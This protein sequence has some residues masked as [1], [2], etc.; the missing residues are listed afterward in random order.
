MRL[1]RL[2]LTRYGR[3]TD[4]RLDFPAPSPG[5]PDLHVIFGPN[6]AGKSTLFSAWLDLLY[7]IPARSRYDF[8]HPG[9]T[10]QIGARLTHDGGV[11]EA[12][13][14]KRNGASLQDANGQPL[15]EAVMQAALAGLG[16]DGYTAMFSLDDDTLEQGGESILASRG[17]LGEMLFSASAGLSGLGP[18]LDGVRK[19]LDAFHKPRARATA[20]K[21]ARD[22]LQDLD[23]QRRDLDISASAA[24]KL[25]RDLAAAEKAWLAAR[26]TEAVADAALK[27]VTE[28]LARLPQ[29]DRL[30]RLRNEL[31]PLATLPAATPE[32][33]R[34]LA[35][36][37]QSLRGIAGQMQTR[38]EALADLVQR[39]ASLSRDPAILPLAEHIAKAAGLY[40]LH[41]AALADL[42]KRRDSLASIEADLSRQMQALGL[43]G[44]PADHSIP[45]TT[46]SR[47]R[48]LV[49]QRDVLMQAFATARDEAA[50]GAARLKSLR[51]AI[52][53]LPPVEDLQSLSHLV[54]RLRQSD[55]E[56][57]VRRA[58]QE[59]AE[60]EG[61]LK[62][63]LIPLAPWQGTAH[64]L[65][66]LGVPAPWQI[67][68]WEDTEKTT[69]R[70]LRDAQ[71][72][73][74]R[75]QAALNEISVPIP[76]ASGMGNILAQAARLRA[77][78][79]AA[80]ATHLARMTPQTAEVFEEALRMDDQMAHHLA[81]AKLAAKW[82]EDTAQT[83]ARLTGEVEAAQADLGARQTERQAFEQALAD[84]A[85]T[86]GL[87]GSDAG[88][89][90][91]RLKAWLALRDSALI[92]KARRD[93][94]HAALDQAGASLK[95]AAETLA[96]ALALPAPTGFSVLWAEALT[97]LD[98]A[99]QR[100]DNAHRLAEAQSDLAERISAQDR[101][102]RAVEDWQGEWQ[103]ACTGTRLTAIVPTDMGLA[104]LLD[105]LDDLNRHED[106]RAELADRIA[107]M[108]ANSA[109][110]HAA[111]GAVFAA[112]SLPAETQW[113]GIADRLAAAQ[114]AAQDDQ[115]ITQDLI[116]LN[117]LQAAEADAARALEG[118]RSALAQRLG[119]VG[120]GNLTDHLARCLRASDL[121]RDIAELEGELAQYPAPS[122][123]AEALKADEHQRQNTLDLARSDTAA[124][125]AELIDT[126]K[127]V[128][129]IGGDDAVSRI[130]AE[131]AN[132]L[133]S[134]AEQAKDHLARRFAVVALEQGL[135]RYR[136]SHRSAMLARASEAFRQLSRGAYS[137][138]AAQ[139]DGLSE[140][141][142]AQAAKGGAKL[143]TDLSKGTRFQLYLALRT[144][145]Y[146]E[147][148][149][150]RPPVPFIADDIM[151]T[152]DDHRAERAFGLLRDMSHCG[153]VIYLTHHRHL[154]EIALTACPGARLLDLTAL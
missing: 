47:L 28:A 4:T 22:R 63:A 140:V 142:V 98:T 33:A 151:E 148:A 152:F 30:K 40:P 9:P 89:D 104:A 6:E 66:A 48:A 19:E 129:A 34:A 113:D 75:R 42:P 133:H 88:P 3:F 118:K 1:D 127:A 124:R 32:N 31:A 96:A 77:A 132:L 78:R 37:D 83:K 134:L 16:R 154:C 110:F 44:Q 58:Q 50:R 73:L 18:Q 102:Q 26:A 8:L 97:R 126:K 123:D 62:R 84:C 20:L 15:P 114:R 94:A 122:D 121:R 35:E 52:G 21:A 13:R 141:L 86:L 128:C 69:A 68:G 112:L 153:Q 111:A 147:L 43:T 138:L 130:A 54:A 39:K 59:C 87:A 79:E 65:A 137:G 2:D 139:P 109:A 24:Q 93:Q 64:D 49:A 14:L 100:T 17:D 146:H 136:D 27:Q 91:A 120:E 7:G 119:W 80:W 76:A 101:A 70:V 90:L 72:S 145:G 85:R 41:Q 107:K 106:E 115:Q 12:I 25:Q 116:R 61:E 5:L 82:A 53:D 149:K 117:A 56:V 71:D 99:K 95:S 81:E 29:Q 23:R 10:M 108:D 11:L 143:A 103:L 57:L 105:Q 74:D 45:P 38:N 51:D 60:C 36:I 46:L 150:L 135:R 131:R 92:A 125:Y 67:A 144:A 55:P